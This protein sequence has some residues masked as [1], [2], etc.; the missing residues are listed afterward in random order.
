MFNVIHFPPP[1]NWEE[2]NIRLR[3]TSQE[4][5]PFFF[6]KQ[7]KETTWCWFSPTSLLEKPCRGMHIRTGEPFAGLG[8]LPAFKPEEA[9]KFSH[10]LKFGSGFRTWLETQPHNIFFSPFPYPTTTG[11]WS[12]CSPPGTKA[13]HFCPCLSLT[14]SKSCALCALGFLGCQRRLCTSTK[15]ALRTELPALHSTRHPWFCCQEIRTF[16]IPILRTLGV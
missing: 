1:E 11:A 9:R 5:Q 10:M 2:C 4:T 6:C 13:V 8:P 3:Q 16:L 14:D 7:L 15:P 12:S